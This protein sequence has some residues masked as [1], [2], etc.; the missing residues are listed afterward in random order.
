MSLVS[1]S[2]CLHSEAQALHGVQGFLINL[3]LRFQKLPSCPSHNPE[4][5]TSSFLTSIQLTSKVVFKSLCKALPCLV[6]SYVLCATEQD[7]Y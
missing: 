3:I 4:N 1:S 5:P 7:H 2:H 6:L